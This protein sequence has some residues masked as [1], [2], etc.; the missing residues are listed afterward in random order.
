MQERNL[1]NMSDSFVLGV[2]S[3]I[4]PESDISEQTYALLRQCQI[5]AIE[6]GT[7]HA[8]PALAERSPCT[9]LIALADQVSPYIYSLHAPYKP[10]RDLSL[11]DEQRRLVAVGHTEAALELA[12]RLGASVVTIHGSEEPILMSERPARREQTRKSLA[13]LVTKASRLNLRLAL[14]TMPPEWIPAGVVEAFDAVQGL[15]PNVIGF[16]LDTNH[17]NLTDDLAETVRALGSR[18]WNVHL[19]DNDGLNQRHWMPFQGVIDWEALMTSLCEVN[20]TGPLVYE[21]N[22]RPAGIVRGLEDIRD[23]FERLL[24]LVPRKKAT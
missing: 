8:G 14:E 12:S 19:S 17:S 10:D 23:N 9:K 21:V 2:S 13:S 4:F 22:P 1:L 15:D 11:L 20:Y 24:S 3:C 5:A 16:C 18:I 6:I 7:E